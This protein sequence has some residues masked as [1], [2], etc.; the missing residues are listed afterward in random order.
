MAHNSLGHSGIRTKVPTNTTA[1]CSECQVNLHRRNQ[2][3]Q[4]PRLGKPTSIS[5]E[6]PGNFQLVTHDS[7]M[8]GGDSIHIAHRHVESVTLTL[9]P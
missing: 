9:S 5:E 2:F 6:Q 1:P 8:K 4:S 3:L 7:I